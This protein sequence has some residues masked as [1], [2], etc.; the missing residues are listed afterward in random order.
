MHVNKVASYLPVLD[1]MR[2]KP[3]E[4][5]HV[6]V[7]AHHDVSHEREKYRMAWISSIFSQV[8]WA[9]VSYDTKLWGMLMYC[10][11]M[12]GIGIRA[13]YRLEKLNT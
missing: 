8:G 12:L 13:L 10:T 7:V 5:V 4:L 1:L 6:R 9:Y 11:I 2:T 3:N